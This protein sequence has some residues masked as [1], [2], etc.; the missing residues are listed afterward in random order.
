LGTSVKIILGSINGIASKK[1][2]ALGNV[3]FNVV[4]SLVAY[5]FMYP[6]IRLIHNGMGIHDPLIA[7]VMFQSLIN[8]VGVILFVLFLDVFSRFLEKR[9]AKTDDQA[10]LYI[11][12]AATPEAAIA[13]LEKESDFF[14]YRVLQLNLDAFHIT[15]NMISIPEDLISETEEF[16]HRKYSE[17]YETI[18]QAEGEILSFYFKLQKEKPG[19]KGLQRLE[20][21]VASVRNA[22]YSAKSIKDVRHNRKDFRNSAD[23]TKYGHYKFFQ[24][25]LEKFYQHINTLLH[26][27]QVNANELNR[28][29]EIAKQDYDERTNHIYQKAG[30]DSLEEADVSTM[31]NVSRELY[32]SAKAIIYAISDS[33]GIAME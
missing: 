33:K 28:L 19:N 21:L 29:L 1:R 16:N 24:A 5:T 17:K 8:L 6:L 4:I 9:Y 32:N 23:D 12:H 30:E 27:R 25:Q 2:I 3:L 22:M 11:G 18:K 7:L 15:Q 31:L 20:Q 10:T 14:I 26:H 13:A